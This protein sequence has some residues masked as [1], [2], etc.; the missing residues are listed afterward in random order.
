MAVRCCDIDAMSTVLQMPV[1]P[2]SVCKSL[3]GHGAAE[4]VIRRE[5][6]HWGTSFRL[7]NGRDWGQEQPMDVQAC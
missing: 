1:F 5:I 3:Q 7:A 2:P 6:K 4:P